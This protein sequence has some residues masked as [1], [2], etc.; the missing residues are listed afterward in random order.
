MKN[1][2]KVSVFALLLVACSS[3]T[4]QMD[5][6]ISAGDGSTSMPPESDASS[7]PCPAGYICVPQNLD[8]GTE[9]G[10]NPGTGGNVG[11]STSPGTGGSAG[12]GGQTST[13]STTT[14]QGTGGQAGSGTGGSTP[15]GSGGTPPQGTGG[16]GGSGTGG[17]TVATTG[18]ASSTS[19]VPKTVTGKKILITT[20]NKTYAPTTSNLFISHFT[21]RGLKVDVSREFDNGTGHAQYLDDLHTLPVSFSSYDAVISLMGGT[22]PRSITTPIIVTAGGFGTTIPEEINGVPTNVK[23]CV[24]H[25]TFHFLVTTDISNPL[26]GGYSSLNL[27]SGGVVGMSGRCT[28]ASPAHV[29][30]V[31]DIQYNVA[32]WPTLYYYTAG[33]ALPD[34]TTSTNLIIGFPLNPD[35]ESVAGWDR[36]VTTAPV[37]INLLDAS[38]DFALGL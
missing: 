6:S 10:V 20:T 26:A 13:T 12:A 21:S 1:T 30:M 14:P 18:T 37:V 28:N 25:D 8:S 27:F 34:G 4:N 32:A 24:T 35:D 17:T 2:A 31:L 23:N 29:A 33:S 15:Q 3:S 9:T 38:V 11:G 36:V 22:V 7:S 19:Y 5:A 16:T